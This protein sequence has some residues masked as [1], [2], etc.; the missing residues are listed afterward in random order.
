MEAKMNQWNKEKEYFEENILSLM[1]HR[2]VEMK[3][4]FSKQNQQIGQMH[5]DYEKIREKLNEKMA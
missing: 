4:E 1:E 2:K 3:R 5:D